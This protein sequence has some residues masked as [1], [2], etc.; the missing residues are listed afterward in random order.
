M[1][2]FSRTR[3]ADFNVVPQNVEKSKDSP[4]SSGKYEQDTLEFNSAFVNTNG[5]SPKYNSQ[6]EENASSYFKFEQSHEQ[7]SNTYVVR[8]SYTGTSQPDSSLASQSIKEE[9]TICQKSKE[10]CSSGNSLVAKFKQDPELLSKFISNP[11]LVAKIFQDQRVL[12]KIMMDPDL[13]TCFAADPHITQF[14][15]ENCAID[16]TDTIDE[17]TDECTVEMV[18]QSETPK[19]DG[20]SGSSGI[21]IRHALKFKGSHVEN[22]ILT[23][24]ITNRNAEECK[25]QNLESVTSADWSKNPADVTRDVLQDVQRYE[26][27][28]C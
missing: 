9:A 24:L 8:V 12:M 18:D 10:T 26:R 21:T 7:N 6:F 13:A 2:V 11:N 28:D 20:I 22:P 14:L 3:L 19:S 15:K 4:T 25:N 5:E 16:V 27:P 1:S 23:D 17:R